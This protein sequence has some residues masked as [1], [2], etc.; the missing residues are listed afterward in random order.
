M[1][2][3]HPYGI[4]YAKTLPATAADMRRLYIYVLSQYVKNHF[5][6]EI[7]LAMN[8]DELLQAYCA[9]LKRIEDLE[10][11]FPKKEAASSLPS[12]Q[13]TGSKAALTE[14]IY[15]LQSGGVLNHGPTPIKEI[16][17]KME[18]IFQVE[19]GNYYHCFNEIRLRKKN[20]TALLDHLREK[21]LEK[22]DGMDEG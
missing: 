7:N 16:A 10:K 11:R 19:L 18:K 22:M 4:Y 1:G 2:V 20:R 9:L 21:V 13:W 8:P 5:P 3:T 15:A 12:F 6:D 17:E 14:L